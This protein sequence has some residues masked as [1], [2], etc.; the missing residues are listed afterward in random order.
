MMFNAFL[1]AF[2]FSRIARA[3]NRASQVIMS[4]TCCVRTE[5]DKWILEV[6]VLSTQE[7]QDTLETVNL[8][9]SS[10]QTINSRVQLFLLLAGCMSGGT[11]RKRRKLAGIMIV[12]CVSSKQKL[13]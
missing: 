2:V 7:Q 3:E 10:T 4:S 11:T 13:V 5:G 12:A 8:T 1:L 6:R 9:L